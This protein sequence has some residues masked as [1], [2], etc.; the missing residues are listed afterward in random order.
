MKFQEKSPTKKQDLPKEVKFIDNEDPTL[1]EN[2]LWLQ[3]A[4]YVH[5]TSNNLGGGRYTGRGV[6]CGRGGYEGRRYID[7]S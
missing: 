2:K 1:A 4:S 3:L 5:P 6:M 7:G